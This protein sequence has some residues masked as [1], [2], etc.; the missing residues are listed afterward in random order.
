MISRSLVTGAVLGVFALSGLLS[1][2]NTLAAPAGDAASQDGTTTFNVYLPLTHTDAL[3]ELLSQ[4]TDITSINYHK[5]LTP[6]Q[7]KKQFG[8]SSTAF[9]SAR[10]SL[11]SAGFTIVAENTQ[12]LAVRG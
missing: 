5:W 8:P 3:E 2:G 4:Q 6:A 9:A 12:N 10:A 1:S 7:F 11:E